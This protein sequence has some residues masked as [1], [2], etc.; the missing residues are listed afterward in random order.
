MKTLIQAAA[1]TLIASQAAHAQ[2]CAVFARPTDTV[3]LGTHSNFS[4]DYTVE[5]SGFPLNQA[6]LTN[7]PATP[8]ARVWSEQDSVTEDKGIGL[9]PDRTPAAWV[10]TFCFAV[11]QG[12]T[13]LPVVHRVHVALVRA[14]TTRTLYVNGTSVMT[15]S[16]PCVPLNGGSSNMALGAFV[17]VNQP[18]TNYWRAAPVALDWIRV[19]NS[20]RYSGSFGPPS[21]SSLIVDGDTQ[22]LMTFEG[23]LPWQNLADLA[24]TVSLGTGV[25]GGTAPILSTD[26]NANGVPDQAEIGLP[27]ADLNANG[28]L[29][30]CERPRQWRIADG[31]N[32]HWYAI[33]PTVAYWE[34]MRFIAMASGGHLA[35]ITSA[36]ENHF[37]FGLLPQSSPSASAF[38]IGGSRNSSGVW[39]WVTGE[40]WSYTNWDVGEPNGIGAQITWIY[41]PGAPHPA[42]WNDHPASDYAFYGVIEY[43]AD[44]NEDGIVDFGQI[45]DGTFSDSNGN[46]I[47]DCCEGGGSCCVGDILADRV[48]N[49]ADLGALLAYWGSVTTS[50][51]SRACDLNGDNVVNGADIGLL[52]S[53]WGNCP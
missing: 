13:P 20:A 52:L 53:G 50:P 48:I 44:C 1:V 11:A 40:P 25:A 47:P 27:D 42:T 49:G 28:T 8:T 3:Q 35:T 29:D 7:P 31:G 21:E 15:S 39:S 14:G 24:T 43:E 4:G 5:W 30:D 37:V 22:L 9:N 16:E 6:V 32:G 36:G 10:N 34:Q 19:S 45:L 23:N 2:T 46:G 12:A 26:C 33:S 38:F 17:Y 18:A 41:G 51:I